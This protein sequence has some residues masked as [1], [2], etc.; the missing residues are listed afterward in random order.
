[1][2]KR[3][4]RKNMETRGNHDSGAS[5]IALDVI[6]GLLAGNYPRELMYKFINECV[7]LKQKDLLLA[8]ASEGLSWISEHIG[9]HLYKQLCA[10]F[11]NEEPEAA[12]AAEKQRSES[13]AISAP[14]AENPDGLPE[15]TGADAAK[16][17]RATGK[18]T[19]RKKA[20]GAADGK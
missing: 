4:E 18:R 10:M 2:E 12:G 16:K 14:A 5:V 11:E 9:E 20:T 19:N 13:E 7:Q 15:K 1:M 17:Q 3:E 8:K 6:A